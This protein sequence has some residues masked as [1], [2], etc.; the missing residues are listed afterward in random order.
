QASKH[1]GTMYTRADDI[2]PYITPS[3]DDIDVG[4][5]DKVGAYYPDLDDTNVIPFYANKAGYGNVFSTNFEKVVENLNRGVLMWVQDSHG[6]HGDS[7]KVAFW[8]P[9]SPYI[10]EENPWRAYEPVMLKLGHS[11][12]FIRW[13]F[14]ML[15]EYMGMETLG[16]LAEFEPIKFQLFPEVGSTENP[17]GALYNPSLSNVNRVI[18]KATGGMLEILGAFGF[19]IHWDRLFNN[20]DKLPLITTYDGMITTSTRSGSGLIEKTVNGILFDDELKNLHSCGINTVVCLPAGTYL[21]MTWIRHGAT[22]TIMDPWGTS[23]Y[24]AV[25][26]QSI[27]K[28]LALGDTIGQAYE[29]GVRAVGPE[30]LVDQWWWDMWE[31]VCFYGDPDLRVF[32]P[33][34]EYSDANHWT[35]DETQPLMYDEELNLNGHMPYSATS[36]PHAKQ[37]KTFLDHYL[38]LII[39]LIVIA[40]IVLAMIVLGRKK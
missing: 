19:K 7:G 39:I 11:D 28:N 16:K 8:N 38:W 23:D 21:Q 4:A 1:W 5:T 20:P 2:T 14:Y 17:D 9:D 34:T 29:K 22:Y 40:I 30:Y 15:S 35:Q 26:L 33:G 10:Y 24:C 6:F 32:V 27:I 37:P 13:V 3:P 36:Y 25:W 18:E 12:N 31:N